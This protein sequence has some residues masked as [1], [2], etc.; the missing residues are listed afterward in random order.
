MSGA[1]PNWRGERT[2]PKQLARQLAI[3]VL[4]AYRSLL[5]RTSLA[6]R[7]SA[8]RQPFFD[9]REAMSELPKDETDPTPVTICVTTVEQYPALSVPFELTVAG[10]L[11]MDI[12]GAYDFPATDVWQAM[13]DF[14][15]VDD[16]SLLMSLLRSPPGHSEIASFVAR[17]LTG[18]A[19]SH[20]FQ[21][22]VH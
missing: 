19:P 21:P 16:R 4:A 12:A 10:Y 17:K 18:S 14:P 13:R 8:H 22:T 9:E 2:Y 1:D 15:C 20:P 6:T 5:L 3:S 7:L 11:A